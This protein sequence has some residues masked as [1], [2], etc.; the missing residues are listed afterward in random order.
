ML[1]RAPLPQGFRR[2]VGT[3]FGSSAQ[4]VDEVRFCHPS[5]SVCQGQ[6]VVPGVGN[7]VS[8][9]VL[10]AAEL[11]GVSQALVG[12]SPSTQGRW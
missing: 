8:P 6:S 11:R 5:A 12:T 10:A 2:G 7:C 3:R 9:E 4:A 1:P